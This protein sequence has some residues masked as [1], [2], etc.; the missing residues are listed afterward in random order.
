MVNPWPD[1]NTI[2]ATNSANKINSFFIESISAITSKISGCYTNTSL[3]EKLLICN[4]L[5][6]QHVTMN[7]I[8]RVIADLP[9]GNST[10][11]DN[12]SAKMLKYSA[13]C[14]CHVLVDIFNSSIDNGIFPNARKKTIAVPEHKKGNYFDISNYRPII[15]FPLISKV[16]EKLISI[17][18]CN[19]LNNSM[20]INAAQYG[21]RKLRS[22]ES[23]LRLSKTLFA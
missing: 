20:L 19:H 13:P 6:L 7:D 4:Q 8:I 15:L 9:N 21:F 3:P 11:N 1:C 12:I 23:L 5:S 18:I 10:G 22:C 16:F 14:I 2:A 17:Q